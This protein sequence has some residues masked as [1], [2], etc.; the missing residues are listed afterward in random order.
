M[1]IEVVDRQHNLCHGASNG[2]I[3]VSVDGRPGGSAQFEWERFD[4]TIL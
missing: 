2:S 3:S 4:E 1:A